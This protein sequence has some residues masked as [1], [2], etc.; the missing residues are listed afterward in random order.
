M[1]GREHIAQMEGRAPDLE[2]GDVDP[3]NTEATNKDVGGEPPILINF[4][5][6]L[7]FQPGTTVAQVEE[8]VNS[9]DRHLLHIKS[10][11]CGGPAK[12]GPWDVSPGDL[13]SSVKLKQL[14]MLCRDKDRE[15]AALNEQRR[16]LA[17]LME[18]LILL[19]PDKPPEPAAVPLQTPEASLLPTRL[20]R[21]LRKIR[22]RRR[23]ARS[24][25]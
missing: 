24:P 15:I 23:G 8:V 1:A 9:L 22:W 25:G 20:V 12:V 3:V 17:R 18:K 2:T 13:Q 7:E 14:E 5:L 4:P 11:R 10:V 6:R 16:D 19:L 21:K